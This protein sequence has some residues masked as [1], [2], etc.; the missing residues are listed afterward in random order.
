MRE[1]QNPKARRRRRGAVAVE[2][3]IVLPLVL[4]VIFGIIEYGRYIAMLQVFEQAARGGCRYAVVRV[5]DQDTTDAQVKAEVERLMCGL[6]S[7][8]SDYNRNTSIQVFQYDRDHPN[9]RSASWKD[10]AFGK[11]ICLEITGTYRTAVPAIWVPGVGRIPVMG[12]H[13]IRIRS[14]MCSEAN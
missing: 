13:T 2:S 3:A 10:A 1:N 11:L 6:Q 9:D 14:V 4:V 12:D 7:Q 5:V 8:L